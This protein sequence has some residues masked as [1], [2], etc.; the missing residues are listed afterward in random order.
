[1]EISISIICLILDQDSENWRIC[2]EENPAM[3]RVTE[4][5]NEKA[6]VGVEFSY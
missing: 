1:M 4:S 2:T 5:V 6:K 3:K